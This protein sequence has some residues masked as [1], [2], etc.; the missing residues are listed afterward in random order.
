MACA[1]QRAVLDEL[2]GAHRNDDPNVEHEKI[3]FTHHSI[4]KYFLCG[5]CPHELF[6]NTKADKGPCP[7]THDYNILSKYQASSRFNRLGYEEQME[8]YCRQQ[9][10]EI[11]RRIVK[12]K[13]RL[14]LTQSDDQPNKAIAL[15]K[16]KITS[17]EKEISELV[18]KSGEYGNKG[19]IGKAHE[20]MNE[21]QKLKQE[22]RDL[23]MSLAQP[24][25]AGEQKLMEVCVVCGS[26][27]VVND[28]ETRVREHTNGKL[29]VGYAKLRQYIIDREEEKH[30]R[31]SSE[32]VDRSSPP[33]RSPSDDR[34]RR[35]R[36]RSPSDDEGHRN[37]RHRRHRGHHRDRYDR[38]RDRDHHDSRR[39]YRRH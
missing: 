3:D 38:D 29:H 31:S 1:A 24:T 18:E 26:F 23:E 22:K 35:R 27:L 5:F 21:C 12:N 8:K 39:K 25:A 15:K 7:H 19:E 14:A 34:E 32:T 37:S 4:C 17:L 28:A 36:R 16:E 11:E 33:N 6:T 9:I 30:K 10:A 20:F 2:M 13:E